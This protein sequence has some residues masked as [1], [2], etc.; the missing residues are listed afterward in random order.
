[1]TPLLQIAKRNIALSI[2]TSPDLLVTAFRMRV[3]SIRCYSVFHCNSVEPWFAMVSVAR[4]RFR[5]DG[6]REQRNHRQSTNPDKSPETASNQRKR[7]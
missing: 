2:V 5:H 1:M 6:P 3:D 4:T 7:R